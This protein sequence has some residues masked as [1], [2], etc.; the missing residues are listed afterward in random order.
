MYLRYLSTSD[1]LRNWFI[2]SI[3]TYHNFS[4]LLSR[5]SVTRQHIAAML[6]WAVRSVW[7]RGWTYRGGK[8]DGATII[9]T[10]CIDILFDVWFSMTNFRKFNNASKVHRCSTGSNST[11]KLREYTKSLGFLT[12]IKLF[13]YILTAYICK[14]SCHIYIYIIY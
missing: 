1:C 6:T 14:I 10:L 7:S 4:T 9:A 5:A 8:S 12:P 13:L 3:G 11:N 2:S